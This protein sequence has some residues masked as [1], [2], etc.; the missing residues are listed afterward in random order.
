M[1]LRSKQKSPSQSKGITTMSRNLHFLETRGQNF[2]YKLL[3]LIIANQIELA[4]RVDTHTFLHKRINTT[5]FGEGL[6]DLFLVRMCRGCTLIGL[7][8][9]K[10]RGLHLLD[11]HLSLR[12]H[13][14]LH[15]FYHLLHL[16]FLFLEL[17]IH[18]YLCVLI[19]RFE[20][21]FDCS[22][23]WKVNVTTTK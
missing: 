12:H 15:G 17:H 23:L 18:Y 19:D 2:R 8:R 5:K 3:Y 14:L 6:F 4:Q 16:L 11:H 22:F 13:L 7:V 1:L 9:S 20:V 10:I 21:F